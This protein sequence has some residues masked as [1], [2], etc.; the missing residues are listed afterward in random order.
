MSEE[1][2][3]KLAEKLQ[4]LMNSRWSYNQGYHTECW[5]DDEGEVVSTPYL[6]QN[7]WTEYNEPCS[8]RVARKDRHCIVD[9]PDENPDD[10]VDY[11]VWEGIDKDKYE[12]EPYG[13]DDLTEDDQKIFDENMEEIKKGLSQY[14][15]EDFI[16]DWVEIRNKELEN[17]EED[18]YY[19]ELES[20]FCG[21]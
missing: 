17:P 7:N 12:D 14:R 1:N 15:F 20:Y 4:E 3:A 21:W 11:S 19:P 9:I 16:D 18:Y 13:Y 6:S 5:I 8:N 2:R 10:V